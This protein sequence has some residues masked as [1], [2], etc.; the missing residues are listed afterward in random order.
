MCAGTKGCQGWTRS[1][2]GKSCCRATRTH[3]AGGRRRCGRSSGRLFAGP[4][5][6]SRSRATSLPASTAR[7]IRKR[8]PRCAVCC[9]QHS[10]TSSCRSTSSRI[11][12]PSSAFLTTSPCFRPPSP[13]CAAIS[14]QAI[15]TRRTASSPT[16]L[17]IR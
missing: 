2:S 4:C 11:F 8:R 14:G 16:R 7:S 3:R 9:L 10:L 5:G 17:R 13:W 6:R 15:T 12:S 1:S